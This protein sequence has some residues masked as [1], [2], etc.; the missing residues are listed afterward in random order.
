MDLALMIT[1]DF[2]GVEVLA[3]S[4]SVMYFRSDLF[5]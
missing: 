3:R 1:I 4:V 5:R 2:Q